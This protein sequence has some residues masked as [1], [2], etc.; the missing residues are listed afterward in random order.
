MLNVQQITS[1]LARLPDDS[2]QQYA[3]MHK[4]DPYVLSL[5]LSES[6]RRKELRLASQGGVGMQ[7][8]PKVVDQTLANMQPEPLPEEVGIGALPAQNIEQM[9]DG[10]IVGYAEG[11]PNPAS[12]PAGRLAYENEPVLRMA[13][14]GVAR[15][16]GTEGSVTEARSPFAFLNPGDILSGISRI[17]REGVDP[18]AAEQRRQAE[19]RRMVS[20]AEETVGTPEFNAA[21][22]VQAAQ[23]AQRA[24]EAA[25]TSTAES[26]TPPPPLP[27]LPRATPVAGA[28]ISG[29]MTNPAALQ[30]ALGKLT[31]GISPDIPKSLR[32]GI[33]ELQA[34]QEAAANE[35][36]SAIE[37]EQA[38]RQPAFKEFEERL[39]A[40]EA[41]LTGQERQ[42]SSLALLQAGLAIMGG[43][44]PYAMANIGAGAQVGLKAY[45]D[46]AEKLEAAREKIDESMAKIEELRRNESRM[47]AKEIREARLAAKQPA[48]E[49]KKLAVSALE[50]D[51]GLKHQDALKIFETSVQNQRTQYE[52][53][54]ANARAQT[55][56]R[57][58]QLE[59]IQAVQKDPSLAQAYQAL[60]GTKTDLMGQY[61]D[62]LGKNP[63][64]SLEDFLKTKAVF[65]TLSGAAARPVSQLPPGA[66]VAPR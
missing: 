44:S 41:R 7:Q 66:S 8:Q 11:G 18:V 32:T 31:G 64:G 49:A 2:L 62:Y 52:Q 30:T 16:N 28:G 47:D 5:A 20:P 17:F 3:S 37:K 43:T 14:G 1:E 39:K 40:R 24:K 48:I 61:T 29:L 63:T 38:A 65:S 51:W 42:N 57:N 25:A 9:A 55:A 54:Q 26:G 34:A 45:K 12:G 56:A 21:Q 4:D 15:Y 35:N 22:A 53:G 27:P 50:K 13:E 19:L 46:G 60:H 10:G 59:L 33:G 36:V 58:P 23:A 6:N